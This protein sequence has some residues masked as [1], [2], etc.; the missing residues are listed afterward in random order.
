MAHEMQPLESMAR[1][2]GHNELL[3]E[4]H[5][6]MA[7]ATEAAKCRPCGC[8]HSTLT[9][10]EAAA[11]DLPLEAQPLRDELALARARLRSVEYECLGCPTCYPALAANAFAAAFPERAAATAACPT[12]SPE[13]RAGWP[14]LPG[15][16]RVLR[17]RAPVAICTLTE[18][19]LAARLADAQL[20]GVA[21]VGRL[22]TES[23][24]IERAIKN[25]VANPNIGF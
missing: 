20:T 15:E 25:T 21:L 22:H 9:T 7:E 3:A 17:Y 12:D 10:L 6:W 5:H 4:A 1:L 23:L 8:L 16:Y 24:G 13:E 14:P 19:E 11:Q 2:S 18:E